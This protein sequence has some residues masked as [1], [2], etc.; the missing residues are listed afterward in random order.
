MAL[1]TLKKQILRLGTWQHDA[2]P[3]GKLEVTSDYIQKL[4]DNFEKSPFAP[5]TRGHQPDE[6]L[7]EDTSLIVSKN[8][9]GL[10]I[11][12]EGLNA[13]MEIEEAELDKYNDVS[14]S[15]D[16]DYVDHETGLELGPLLRHVA[17][18]PNPFI[19][20]L[21][22]FV[23]MG[24]E[25]NLIINLSEI[26]AKKDTTKVEL[27][28]ETKKV[29][30]ESTEEP[31]E[32]APEVETPK[33]VEA[34]VEPEEEVEDPKVK[35]PAKP[36]EKPVEASETVATIQAYEK[37]ISELEK[38]I[39]AKEAEAKYVELLDAGKVTPAV[40]DVVVNLYMSSKSEI[41]LADGKTVSIKSQLD[42]LFSKL[43]ASIELGERG[44]DVE[45][46]EKEGRI[47]SELR[48]LPAHVN[49]TDKEFEDWYSKNEKSIQS[50]QDNL[51]K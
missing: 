32:E 17:L 45:A 24:E 21:K 2:A 36:E 43:P 39:S 50:A 23:A 15:I 31:V 26:M 7:A 35:E 9:K 18:V 51:S 8:I 5:V 27:E 37:R 38:T 4:V 42:D 16:P 3:N 44:I 22:A 11:D 30:P 48:K 25:H 14:V 41:N 34:P 12:D 46:Q 29:A 19:K 1:K 49:K 10:E 13:L 28:D 40:K 6:K 20:G 33:E 47:K